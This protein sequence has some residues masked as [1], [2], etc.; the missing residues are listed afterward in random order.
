[1]TP[2]FPARLFILAAFIALLS[3]YGTT[4]FAAAP[5]HRHEKETRLEQVKRTGTI[6]C[7]YLVWPPLQTRDPNTG[8][9]GGPFAEILEEAARQLKL[10]IAWT[11]ETSTDHMLQDLAVNRFDMICIPAV[12]SPSR[13][14]EADFSVP[15][16]YH[17]I[18]LYVRKDDTRFDNAFDHVNRPDIKVAAMDGQYSGIAANENFPDAT[19]VSLPQMLNSMDLLMMV[20]T[21]KADVVAM[22][23]HSFAVF[24]KTNPSLLRPAKG[25]PLRMVATGFPLPPDEPAFKDM[26]NTTLAYLHDSGFID[27]T[28][29][30]YDN[31]VPFIRVAKP[32]E[33]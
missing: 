23:P 31:P 24:E 12:Q 8:K 19:H 20:T 11:A 29:K 6:R 16:F 22:D 10:K 2:R 18:E 25:G 17:S 33:E 27:K 28:L 21:K 4:R 9:I 13:A 26:I 32:Y 1:M 3:A 30:K 15:M 5:I 14:R 7:G